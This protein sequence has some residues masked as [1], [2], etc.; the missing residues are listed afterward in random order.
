MAPLV[1]AYDRVIATT[2]EPVSYTHLEGT[3][4]DRVRHRQ[5]PGQHDERARHRRYLHLYEYRHDGVDLSLIHI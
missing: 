4:A 1:A 3:Q 5:R 2:V